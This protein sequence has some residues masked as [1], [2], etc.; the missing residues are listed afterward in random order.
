M[1]VIGAGLSGLSVAFALK[2]RGIGVRVFEQSDRIGGQIRTYREGGFV[3]ESG[4]NT[5]IIS[6]CEVLDLFGNLSQR[7]LLLRAAPQAKRRLI[8]KDGAFHPLPSGFWS[9]LATNLFTWRDKLRILGEPFRKRGIDP[10]ESVADLVRRRLGVS[11]FRYAVD[12]FVGGIYAGDPESLVTRFALPK[13]YALEATYGS[14]IRGAIAKMGFS[15]AKQGEQVDKSIF[16]AVGGLSSFIEALGREIDL[17]NVQLGARIRELSQVEGGDWQI[18]FEVDGRMEQVQAR[19]LVSTVGSYAYRGLFGF[20]SDDDLA[21]IEALRYAPIVQV[22]VGYRHIPNVDFRAFG[23]LI[24]SCED[25]D[26]LGLLNPSACF[27]GR[28]PEGGML[29]SAFLGGMRSPDLIDWPEEKITD[30]LLLR[31]KVMLGIEQRP[32]LLKVFRHPYAIPQYEASTG[33]RLQKMTEIEERFP[34]LILAGNLRDGVGIP[35][36]IAQGYGIAQRLASVWQG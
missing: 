10:N 30:L 21:P 22:A 26:L 35:D 28:A 31:L 4:P 7:A 16:S 15:E 25:R 12:P 34:R 11:Y 23:G 13:L 32:D 36:R 18:S 27:H 24:P 17:A 20:L 8:F 9:A 33:E 29:L 1:A 6:R 19:Y 2:Q 3:F 14:F 5:G